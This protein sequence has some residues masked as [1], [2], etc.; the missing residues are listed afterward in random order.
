MDSNPDSVSGV[1]TGCVCP[2]DFGGGVKGFSVYDASGKR[3]D[4]KKFKEGETIQSVAKSL[5]KPAKMF[6]PS[7]KVK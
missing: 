1:S 4:K 7:V 2:F 6:P 3:V 5:G